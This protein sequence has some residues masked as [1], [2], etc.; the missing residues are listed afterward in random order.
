MGVGYDYGEG[1]GLGGFVVGSGGVGDVDVGLRVGFGCGSVVSI[2][3]RGLLIFL[4]L[5]FLLLLFC[6]F[7]FIPH[8]VITLPI[9]ILFIIA[10]RFLTILRQI[11]PITVMSILCLIRVYRL[12]INRY[13]I[14]FLVN[15]PMF[16]CLIILGLSI[17]IVPYFLL[18]L[19]FHNV[20][21]GCVMVTHY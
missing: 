18:G 20:I 2:R 11:I 10:Y 16:H 6:L 8:D 19:L 9:L 14:Y 13:I 1:F 5:L 21:V 3:Y 12:L 7:Y 4:L 15:T 17:I